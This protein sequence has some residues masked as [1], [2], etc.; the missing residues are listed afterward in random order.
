MAG[1]RETDEVTG[2][3]T[4]G[5]EWDGI[6]ELNTPLPRWWLWTFYATIVWA[7]GYWIVMPAW[8]LIGTYTKGV[9]GYASREV[10]ANRIEQARAAQSGYIAR[11]EAAALSD[12]RA[13]PDLLGFALAGGRSAFA[14]NCSQCHGLGAAGSP[15]FPNLNDDAWL[16]GGT[17]DAIAHSVAYGIRSGHEDARAGPMPAFVRDEV[18]T[19]AQAEDAAQY[20]LSLSGRS[21]DPAAAGRGAD[22]FAEQCVA[23]HKEGGVGNA[24]VGAPNL[25][26]EIWLY[27]GEKEAIVDSVSNG[28]AGVMPSWVDRLSP[29]TIKQLA[30]YVHSL[31]GGQ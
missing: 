1:I 28:R 25:S 24:E 26:D 16:W 21:E 27:G 5:H 13:D 11:I 3:E 29:A 10:V 9:L 30:V 12:I 4:T 7:I 8:P 23:C 31:G 18:L 22:V 19:R 15:G 2:T 17:L 20:V 14:V 6:K